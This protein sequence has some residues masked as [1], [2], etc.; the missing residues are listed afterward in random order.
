[1]AIDAIRFALDGASTIGRARQADM[2]NR[3]RE[4]ELRVAPQLSFADGSA[5]VIDGGSARPPRASARVKSLPLG[6]GLPVRR[7]AVFR[8]LLAVADVV[9]AGGGLLAVNALT[10]NNVPAA[11]AATIPLIV[12]LAKVMGRYERDE[13]VV[14]KSTLDEVP[15]LLSLSAAYTLIWLFV[16][17]LP[18]DYTHVGGGGVV[19]L[20]VTTSAFL[21]IGRA[22]ARLA[23]QRLAPVERALVIGDDEAAKRLIRSLTSDPGAR[24]EVAASVPFGDSLPGPA[25]HVSGDRDKGHYPYEYLS[26]L[27]RELRIQRV[28]L[29][30][31]AGGGETMLDALRATLDAGVKITIVPRLLEVVGSAVEF[32][33]VGGVTLL[34]V[35]R[36]GLSRSSALLKRASDIIGSLVA[37]CVLAPL[38]VIVAVAIRLDSPGPVLFRQPRVGR[39]GTPF[40]MIKFRSMIVNADTQR[41][42]L[43]HLNES[44]GI[45]K[46][47]ADPRIT[48]VG[49]IIR[50]HSI[51]ELPQL[52]NVLRGEMSLVGPRPLILEEDRLIEGHHRGRLQ[53]RPGMTGPWQVLGPVRP[54][55]SEMVKTDFLYGANW[56]LWTD[57]KI[58]LRTLAHAVAGRGA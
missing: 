46:L 56:S 47:Q 2:D 15:A 36:A 53:L 6:A 8:R 50:R 4:Q 30:P 14:R 38:A 1:V 48:R 32:D 44:E 43:A 23:A 34:G 41:E 20:W 9:A 16:A 39:D 58:I 35:R 57:V 28:F 27:V 45:F 37:T 18:A 12:V 29:A 5:E 31:S 3:D 17:L 42:M 25:H 10:R 26:T 51:D 49:R 22:I 19:V 24:V 52:V 40:Q 13:V 55:L 11:S 21:I 33:V 54:T 7:D